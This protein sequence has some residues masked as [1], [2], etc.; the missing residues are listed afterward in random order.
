MLPAVHLERIWP[1]ARPGLS[2]PMGLEELGDGFS[3]PF[4]IQGQHVVSHFRGQGVLRLLWQS[5]QMVL[6]L[7][8]VSEYATFATNHQERSLVALG[9]FCQV[10]RK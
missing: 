1:E 4:W 9:T 8:I 7:K 10:Q 6:F 3:A 5:G 2:F